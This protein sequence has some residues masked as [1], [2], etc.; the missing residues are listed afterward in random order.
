VHFYSGAVVCF[1]HPEVEIFAFASFEEE[2]VV[3]VV[4]FC[5]FVEL[6]EL[7]LCVQLCVF[8]AVR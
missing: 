8:A 2:D 1:A 7:R 3:A 5:E 6:V 4:E